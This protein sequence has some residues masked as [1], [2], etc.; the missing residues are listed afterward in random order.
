M[1]LEVRL[2]E[3]DEIEE[4]R[5]LEMGTSKVQQKD[6]WLAFKQKKIKGMKTRLSKMHNILESTYNYDE[7][8]SLQ[9]LQ[10]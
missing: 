2:P 8:V 1:A 4:E 7:V 9:N 3:L 5:P 6:H 10:T